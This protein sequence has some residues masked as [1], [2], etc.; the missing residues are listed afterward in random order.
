[1]NMSTL[2]MLNSTSI[3]KLREMFDVFSN[4]NGQHSSLGVAN[5]L[6]KTLCGND[7]FFRLEDFGFRVKPPEKTVILDTNNTM[8][9]LTRPETASTNA[10]IPSSKLIEPIPLL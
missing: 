1:M 4:I 2:T 5:V 6:G 9:N 10:S 7:F 3:V 8:Y